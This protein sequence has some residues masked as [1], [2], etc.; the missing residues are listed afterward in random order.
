MKRY[1]KQSGSNPSQRELYI[2]VAFLPEILLKLRVVNNCLSSKVGFISRQEVILMVVALT[3]L[4]ITRVIAA[5]LIKLNDDGFTLHC[6]SELS[7]ALS[8]NQT[9]KR[10]AGEKS[11]A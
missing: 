9:K 6:S 10:L 7:G 5:G 2:P 3:N 1:D 4:M 11:I 8:H